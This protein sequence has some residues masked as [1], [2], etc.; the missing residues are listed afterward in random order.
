MSFCASSTPSSVRVT[1]VMFVLHE[2]GDALVDL[3]VLVARRLA[4][5]ADDERGAR[6]VDEDGVDLVDDGVV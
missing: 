1:D 4:L 2:A 3:L 6:F 5:P